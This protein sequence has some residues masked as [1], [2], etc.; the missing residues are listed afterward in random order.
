MK[1]TLKEHTKEIA[2]RTKVLC[3]NLRE[4]R[5]KRERKSVK[6]KDEPIFFSF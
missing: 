6:K 5:M 4:A 1:I 2:V 3:G